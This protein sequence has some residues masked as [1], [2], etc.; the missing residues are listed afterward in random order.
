MR[1]A[2]SVHS[3]C[4]VMVRRRSSPVDRSHFIQ[5]DECGRGSAGHDG[6]WQAQPSSRKGGDLAPAASLPELLPR[7]RK[8]VEVAGPTPTAK[9]KVNKLP[10]LPQQALP[11]LRKVRSEAGLP[12]RRPEAHSLVFEHIYSLAKERAHKNRGSEERAGSRAGSLFA[13]EP[14]NSISLALPPFKAGRHPDQALPLPPNPKGL[15]CPSQN[16]HCSTPDSGTGH[17]AESRHRRRP[18]RADLDE[19]SADKYNPR[20]RKIL[21]SESTPASSS[22]TRATEAEAGVN[23]ADASPPMGR[24]MQDAAWRKATLAMVP[25]ADVS[26][27]QLVERLQEAA[28]RKTE[29]ECEKEASIGRSLS[30][31]A[32]SPKVP[33]RRRSGLDLWKSVSRRGSRGSLLALTAGSG[34]DAGS[35]LAQCTRSSSKSVRCA[36]PADENMSA[37]EIASVWCAFKR[38]QAPHSSDIHQDY[39]ADFLR[40]LGYVAG[41]EDQVRALAGEVVPYSEMDG[42]EALTFVERCAKR[43]FGRLRAAFDACETDD[44]GKLPV[45]E[46][47]SLMFSVGFM[48]HRT[49][50]AEALEAVPGASSTP[51]DFA[52]GISFD[53]FLEVLAAYRSVQ[54]FTGGELLKMKRS[55]DSFE[56]VPVAMSPQGKPNPRRQCPGL[57]VHLVVD[58]LSHVFGVHA[59]AHANRIIGRMHGGEGMMPLAGKLGGVESIGFDE[60]L[61]LARCVREAEQE[62]QRTVFDSRCGTDHQ[63]RVAAR[64]L[65][66]LVQ[67]LGYEPLESVIEEVLDELGFECDGLLDSND[68]FHFV[69]SFKERDGLPDSEVDM[70]TATFKKFDKDDCDCIN[71]K[72]LGNIMGDLGYN[73]THA[74]LQLLLSD[75]IDVNRSGRLELSEFLRLMGTHREADLKRLR[76]AFS[77]YASSGLVPCSRLLE[78]LEGVTDGPV[79]KG[80]RRVVARRVEIGAAVAFDSFVELADEAR[81][82]HLEDR[83]RNAGFKESEILHFKRI[84]DTC[85]RDGSGDIDAME[86]TG[87]LYIIGLKIR[88]REEQQAVMGKLDDA[89][90]AALAA[91]VETVSER[92]SANFGFWELVQLIRMMKSDSDKATDEL[93][94]ATAQ[95]LGFSSPELEQFRKI[96]IKWS[97]TDAQAEG[98]SS[99]ENSP[100]RWGA[101]SH[102]N[103]APAEVEPGPPPEEGLSTDTLCRLLRSMGMS[104]TLSH[105]EKLEN[106]MKKFETTNKGLL[107]FLGFLR[108]MRWLLESDFAG[109]NG[110]AADAVQRN[111]VR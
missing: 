75:R 19:E 102:S 88:T 2:R 71:A 66:E 4:P 73:L 107:S 95:E 21:R 41:S 106:Q 81:R 53:K 59:E 26:D 85:D 63:D 68:F 3:R 44:E 58:A 36:L 40:Y 47:R 39:L 11:E 30:E 111:K 86:I 50:L 17:T 92:G 83:R 54:G 42:E 8:R 28:E 90:E 35:S 109:I 110:A 91:G 9:S 93:V 23:P 89:R 38:Y 12:K 24:T 69:Q 31:T 82:V 20:V 29:R 100:S 108:M 72:E 27:K 15:R 97:R 104:M 45:P 105:K 37:T 96:F 49:A 79:P 25:E 99:L 34:T 65:L 18:H 78:V 70:Y 7:Q 94:D 101:S 46:L 56:R 16:S 87:L 103:T 32:T 48:P 52:Q 51:N 55:F 5:L 10:L 6:R 13:N 77:E 61:I 74:E 33:G 62:A 80:V 14:E 22:V 84:F 1:G 98:S 67:T 57:R 64:H 76:A 43:Q 60:F